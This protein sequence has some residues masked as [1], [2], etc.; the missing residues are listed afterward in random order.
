VHL[1][2]SS[3][4]SLWGEARHHLIGQRPV[5]IVDVERFK[6]RRQQALMIASGDISRGWRA[7][8]FGFDP[9][10]TQHPLHP[11]PARKRHHQHCCTLFSGTSGATGAMLQRLGIARDFDM[12]HQSE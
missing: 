7:D 11:L 6:Q 8:P 3:S 12:D 1:D 9:R 2:Q 10:A 5:I 4:N